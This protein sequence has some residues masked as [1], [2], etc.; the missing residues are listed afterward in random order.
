[1]RAKRIAV[2]ALLVLGTLFWT[3]FGLGLWAERQVLDTDEWVDTSS[4][5]LEDEA[6]RNAL[7]V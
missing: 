6:I 2:G 1:V 4:S 5:L 7:G 3:A